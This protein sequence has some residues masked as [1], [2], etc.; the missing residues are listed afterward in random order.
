MRK[1]TLAVK[2]KVIPMQKIEEAFNRT[3]KGDVKFR[4]V[5]DMNSLEE[6]APG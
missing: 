5:I 1:K 3:V 6:Q 4:F 2:L